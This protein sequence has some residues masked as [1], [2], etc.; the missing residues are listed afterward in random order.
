MV[1]V[2]RV[3]LALNFPIKNEEKKL[4]DTRLRGACP[5]QRLLAKH[6][7]ELLYPHAGMYF[8]SF[9]NNKIL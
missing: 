8:P 1:A 9:P 4:V 2:E 6:V 3:L 7:Y 5:Q